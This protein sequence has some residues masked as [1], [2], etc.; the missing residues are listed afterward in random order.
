MVDTFSELR[1]GG[2]LIAPFVSYAVA[3]LILFFPL[4]LILVRASIHRLFSAS[5]IVE[6]CGYVLILAALFVLF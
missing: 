2:V 3:A 5:P 6:V 1:L 4:R